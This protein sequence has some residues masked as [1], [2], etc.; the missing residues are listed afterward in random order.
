MGL[1][2]AE[3]GTLSLLEAPHHMPPL[4]GDIVSW[5]PVPLNLPSAQLRALMNNG[6]GVQALC[7]VLY[8]LI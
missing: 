4:P 2:E 6:V 5:A 7:Y 8:Y 3:M 1:L